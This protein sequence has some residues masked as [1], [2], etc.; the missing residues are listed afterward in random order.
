MAVAFGAKL[1]PTII[2][3]GVLNSLGNSARLG[4]SD[5][6]VLESDESDGSFLKLPITY[7]IVTNID[8]EHLDYYRSFNRL[9]NS[10][11]LFIEKTPS[12]GK[13]L[14]CLD[15]NNLKFLLHKCRTSNFLTY[16]FDKKS[17]YQ[18]FN[19]IKKRNCSIFDLKIQVV[20]S[21]IYKVHLS[22]SSKRNFIL[23]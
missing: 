15:D 13:T 2:N 10:F 14:I 7:S 5:W 22:Y 16:G 18:I 23:I 12:F 8:K 6:C 9:K 19:V 21:K 17:N 20:G 4:K 1:D 11:R 3:G